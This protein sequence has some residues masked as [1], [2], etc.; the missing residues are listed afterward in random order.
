MSADNAAHPVSRKG[1][2]LADVVRAAALLSCFASA[3]WWDIT[4]IIRFVVVFVLLLVP[5]IARVPGGFDL[6]FS[7]T[8]LVAA[9]SG[10]AGWYAQISWWDIPVHLLTTGA[11]AAMACFLLD[12][13]D[14]VHP[15]VDGSGLRNRWRLIT[16]TLAFGFTIAVL[17]EFLEWFG[18]A[19]ISSSIHVGYVDTIGD[20]AAGGAGSLLAGVCVIL[21]ASRRAQRA[22]VTES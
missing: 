22:N 15:M 10:V 9:W 3:I 8:V 14:I 12:R 17:W 4:E 2:R 20:M 16:L 6:A 19:F 13:A 21:W 11:C 5:R 7:A 18:N 1:R